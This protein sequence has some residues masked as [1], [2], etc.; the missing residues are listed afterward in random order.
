MASGGI[1]AFNLEPSSSLA[2]T[3]GLLASIVLPN[4]STILWTVLMICSL[5]INDTLLSFT[6]FPAI[7][8]YISFGP[9]T[10]IS[11]I[12]SFL[13]KSVIGPYPVI[14]LWIKLKIY[15]LSSGDKS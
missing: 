10:I 7:S 14:S 2:S 13:S 6:N 11:V 5:F 4:G 1:I 3:I 12:L 15:S 8:T 9:L